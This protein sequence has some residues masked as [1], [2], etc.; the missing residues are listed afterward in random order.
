MPAT[1]VSRAA[2]TRLEPGFAAGLSGEPHPEMN[3][4]VV[5]GEAAAEEHLRTYVGLL[6]DRGRGGYVN[7]SQSLAAPLE[8]VCL[9]LGLE[10]ETVTP[11]MTRPPDPTPRR[12]ASFVVG[13]ADDAAG[14]HA[15]AVVTAQAFA[16]P[17]DQVDRAMGAGA[18]AVPGVDY[19]VAWANGTP[20]S[21]AITGTVAGHVGFFNVATVPACARHGAATAV[22]EYAID[23]HA[24]HARLYLLT[25]SDEGRGLYERCGF[26]TVELSP[27]WLLEQNGPLQ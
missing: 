26:S 5:W 17:L 4:G 6:R 13:R 25:A 20:V 27:C 11:L 15:V 9:D 1:T 22:T 8:P 14:R 12:G 18:Q 24:A 23:F 7:L 10:L 2:E 3:Y 21:C 16:V 19:F